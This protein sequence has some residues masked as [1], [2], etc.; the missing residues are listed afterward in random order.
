[1]RIHLTLLFALLAACATTGGKPAPQKGE[2]GVTWVAQA[3]PTGK[4]ST[5][6]ILVERGTPEKV[7]LGKPYEY[8]IRLTNLTD[9]E[10]CDVVVDE[11]LGAGVT[12][13]HAE[14][15][16]AAAAGKGARL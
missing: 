9:H 4:T 6:A 7:A 12:L 11:D 5:S 14:P 8:E 13:N 15:A 1:M 3:L 16:P 10:L 2:P